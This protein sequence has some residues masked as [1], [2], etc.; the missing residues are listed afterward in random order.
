MILRQF[1]IL[2]LANSKLTNEE[3]HE[4]N[5]R[6]QQKLTIRY[7]RAIRKAIKLERKLAKQKRERS[8]YPTMAHQVDFSLNMGGSNKK[9]N[10]DRIAFFLKISTINFWFFQYEKNHFTFVILYF[11]KQNLSSSRTPPHTLSKTLSIR[12]FP[13]NKTN[14]PTKTTNQ[15]KISNRRFLNKGECKTVFLIPLESPSST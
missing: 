4:K 14:I 10:K 15:F 7:D 3:L 9:K 11:Y 13:P 8:V 1:L 2:S 5:M 12:I 6:L